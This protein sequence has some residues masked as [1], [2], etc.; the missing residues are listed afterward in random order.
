MHRNFFRR[1]DTE[2][3]LVATDF[4]DDDRDVVVD[5]DALVFLP[6]QYQHEP[7]LRR[8][9]STPDGCRHGYPAQ[10]KPLKL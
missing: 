9:A 4:N 1:L 2:P 7:F 3:H 5:D 6:R 10:L 8:A